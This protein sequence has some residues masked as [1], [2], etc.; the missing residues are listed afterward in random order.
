MSR[1][2]RFKRLRGLKLA[3]ASSF[4]NKRPQ[5][6]P[7]LRSYPSLTRAVARPKRKRGLIGFLQPT[8]TPQRSTDIDLLKVQVT[9]SDQTSCITQKRGSCPIMKNNARNQPWDQCGVTPVASK[10]PR[11]LNSSDGQQIIEYRMSNL[12]QVVP[13]QAGQRFQ[14]LLT[15]NASCRNGSNCDKKNKNVAHFS[16]NA[17]CLAGLECTYHFTNACFT[18]IHRPFRP[19]RHAL[20]KWTDRGRTYTEPSTMHA[21][22]H[23][24]EIRL[25]WLTDGQRHARR[26][27]VAPCPGRSGLAG[28]LEVR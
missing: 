16:A 24:G 27:A 28:V 2:I 3:A 23:R 11:R 8:V 19:P 15:H 17:T 4:E 25:I 1:R 21:C 20:E 5:R 22:T 7:A 12:K 18:K 26:L 6:V 13:N 14:K 10:T 9:Q